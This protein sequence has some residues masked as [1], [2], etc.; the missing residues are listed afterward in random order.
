MLVAP[1]PFH[2]RRPTQRLLLLSLLMVTL[3]LSA[4]FA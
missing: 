4:N 1:R 2:P 3:L